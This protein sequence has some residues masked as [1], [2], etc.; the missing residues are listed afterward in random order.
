MKWRV[1]QNLSTA[2][3]LLGFDVEAKIIK[4]F[5]EK[6]LQKRSVQLHPRQYF[7]E[8]ATGLKTITSPTGVTIRYKERR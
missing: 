4:P 2:V 7:P 5:R 1:L 6:A 8:E 3:L